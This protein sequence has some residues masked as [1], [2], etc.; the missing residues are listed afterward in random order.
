M[1][2]CLPEAF[3]FHVAGESP[4]CY[5]GQIVAGGVTLVVVVVDMAVGLTLVVVVAF[6]LVHVVVGVRPAFV[7][8]ETEQT[9]NL[10]HYVHNCKLQNRVLEVESI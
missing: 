6:V 1:C 4:E 8:C 9:G 7:L 5:I 10:P 2:H 3:R